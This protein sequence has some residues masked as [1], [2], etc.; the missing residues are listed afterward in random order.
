MLSKAERYRFKAAECAKH[1]EVISDPLAKRLYEDL[2]RHWLEL[3]A[4]SERTSFL[5]SLKLRLGV[6]RGRRGQSLRRLNW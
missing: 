2:A 4:A 6:R 5:T 3:A 1:A